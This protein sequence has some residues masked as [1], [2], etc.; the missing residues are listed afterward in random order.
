MKKSQVKTKTKREFKLKKLNDFWLGVIKG[1]LWAVSI[2]LIAILLF[3]VIIRFTNLS[4]S[5]IMPINQVIKIFSILIGCLM[6]TK[7]NPQK[8]LK[9]GFFIG[10]I[11]SVLA[12]LIFSILSTSFSFSMTTIIDL[13]FASLIGA[14]CGVFAVNVANKNK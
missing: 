12:Y 9:M 2:S 4:D 14:I 11:Y 5:F 10:L 8:G 13:V 1:S 7:L 3:A 6:A